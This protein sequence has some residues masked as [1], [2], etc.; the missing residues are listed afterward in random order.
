MDIIK[1]TTP[2]KEAEEILSF[3]GISRPYGW[4]IAVGMLLEGC[5]R[6]EVHDYGKNAYFIKVTEEAGA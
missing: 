1:R 2:I 3:H 5:D 6:L 4:E